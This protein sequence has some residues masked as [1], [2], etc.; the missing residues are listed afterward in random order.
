MS[1]RNICDIHK[2][3]KEYGW[4]IQKI[5]PNQYDTIEELLSEVQWIADRI[6][7]VADEALTS[8]NSMEGRLSEYR[9]TIES[10]GFR[11]SK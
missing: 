4:S 1:S 8:G 11:R 2:E 6:C 10:L 9:D 5:K 7:D 3:I